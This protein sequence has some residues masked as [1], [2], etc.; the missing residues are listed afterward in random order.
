L[1]NETEA[2]DIN[3]LRR[4]VKQMLTSVEVDTENF[5]QVS[6]ADFFDVDPSLALRKRKLIESIKTAEI[7]FQFEILPK[8]QKLAHQT[9]ENA[10]QN[11]PAQIDESKLPPPPPGESW[12]ADKVIGTAEKLIDTATKAGGLFTKAYVFA[13]A[14]GLAVGVP[15]P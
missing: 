4:S 10:R 8:I 3:N 13:K 2:I 9:V 1:L 12:T 15:I 11:P 6:E 7:E 5:R 14:I